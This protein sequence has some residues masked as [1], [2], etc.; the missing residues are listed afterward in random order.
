DDPAPFDEDIPMPF[1]VERGI[2]FGSVVTTGT[3]TVRNNRFDSFNW[4]TAIDDGGLGWVTSVVPAGG[5]LL[6]GQEQTVTVTVDRAPLGVPLPPTT[7]SGSIMVV[8]DIGEAE[9]L[10]T[11]PVSAK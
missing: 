10:L 11:L 9:V 5:V 4:A 8:T 1:V 6:P 7:Y 2:V 3:F